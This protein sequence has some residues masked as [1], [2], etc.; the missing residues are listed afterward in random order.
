[1][2]LL[3]AIKKIPLLRPN[4][5]PIADNIGIICFES[6]FASITK[7][8]LD[9]AQAI[10]VIDANDQ[11]LC[12]IEKQIYEQQKRKIQVLP[13]SEISSRI[14]LVFVFF[15]H[16]SE[17]KALFWCHNYMRKF[18]YESFCTFMPYPDQL[19]ASTIYM[20]DFYKNNQEYLEK[21]YCM[22]HDDES[23]I[24][25]ASRIR[26]IT[27]GKVG[28]LHISNFE[29][30]FHPAVQ[31]EYGDIIIDGGI[32][33]NVSSQI[34]F[35]NKIGNKG[36]W[37]GFEPDPIGFVSAY[38]NIKQSVSYNNF[39]LIDCG[40]WSKRDKICF[41]SHGDSSTCITKNFNTI[42]IDVISIDEFVA[43]NYLNNIDY[44]KLDV[45]G[46]EFDVLKGATRT[47]K[48]FRPKLAI[49]LYHN[50]D[51]IFKLPLFLNEICDNYN[52]HIGHHCAG[53]HETILYANP[54]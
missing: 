5:L 24:I 48:E 38:D 30:Y 43:S 15:H 8:L 10:F 47:I 39:R 32:S 4:A 9:Y 26:A 41:D 46:V 28:Y 36:K 21:V 7:G 53:L 50:I 51:D 23:K 54:I 33:A 29:Q 17:S 40:L 31:P 52:F 34:K 49:S 19:G 22:L 2:E 18:D 11:Q 20:P 16:N 35:I 12:V 3:N 1:M 42:Q 44:I 45:E 13:L 6:A 14:D 37:F 27:S 25:F